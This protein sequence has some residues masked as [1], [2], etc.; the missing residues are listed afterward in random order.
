MKNLLLSTIIY[1]L[2]N[3]VF[4]KETGTITFTTRN[5]FSGAAIISNIKIANSTFSNELSTDKNGSVLI[6][7]PTGIYNFEISSDKFQSQKSNYTIEVNKSLNINVSLDPQIPYEL[8]S[9][10]DEFIISGFVVDK[11]TSQPISDVA[12]LLNNNK[13]NFKTNVD[14]YFKFKMPYKE[15]SL[16]KKNNYQYISLGLKKEGYKL[17]NYNNIL[18]CNGTVLLKIELEKGFG[19]VNIIQ[20]QKLINN[21]NIDNLNDD[22]ENDKIQNSINKM[23]NSNSEI[24]IASCSPQSTIRLYHGNNSGPCVSCSGCTTIEQMSLEYYVRTGLDDEWI[25]SWNDASLLAGAVAYRTYGAYHI[26]HPYLGSS[27][28]DIVAYPCRQHWNGSTSYNS[29][30]NATNSTVN[31]VL[32][33][34]SGNIVFSEY[35]AET[36]NFGC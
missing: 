12:L 13:V 9:S 14:G 27:N 3:S 16:N 7:L 10:K 26:L 18:M 29:T 31:E 25:A 30:I 22:K 34:S 32:V 6:E 5:S 23:S 15:K 17:I 35:A 1:L 8:E 33:N 4:S 36:N 20:T 28:Y 11:I 19:N 21:V 24:S 2:T